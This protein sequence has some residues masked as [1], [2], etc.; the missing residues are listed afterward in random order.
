MARHPI[1]PDQQITI[2]LPGRLIARVD[3]YEAHLHAHPPVGATRITRALALRWA[4]ER[5][6][7][8]VEVERRARGDSRLTGK[9]E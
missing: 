5:G 4:L 3:S 9:E 2:R 1:P 6:L 8:V 7:E